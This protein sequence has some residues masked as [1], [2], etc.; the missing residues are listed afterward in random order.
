MT[1]DLKL[2]DPKTFTR[3]ELAKRWNCDISLI[4][5]YIKN[6]QLKEGFDTSG[7]DYSYL[8]DLRF[9]VCPADQSI[10]EVITELNEIKAD[11]WDEFETSRII[12]CPDYLYMPLSDPSDVVNQST[13][14]VFGERLFSKD[15]ADWRTCFRDLENNTLF[16]VKITRF[17][18]AVQIVSVPK[19]RLED[20]IISLEEVLRF[21]KEHRIREKDAPSTTER[22]GKS[23][24][25]E[26]E[27]SDADS[28]KT[29]DNAPIDKQ[30]PAPEERI[31]RM[32]DL[33][34]RVGISKSHIYKLIADGRFPKQQPITGKKTKGWKESVIND[35]I[36]GKWKKEDD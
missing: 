21:E 10:I 20:I 7:P 32:K 13:Y 8:H 27:D 5:R 31:L 26:R 35:W 15:R 28:S 33:P 30:P 9:I 4:D 19:P 36:E 17:T 22:K 23:L 34:R 18:G 6:G 25:K 11:S 3:K 1:T 14:T 12:D 29:I 16:P 24:K 2:P